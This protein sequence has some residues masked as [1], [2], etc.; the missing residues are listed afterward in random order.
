MRRKQ[1]GYY[2]P[3]STTGE[4]ADAFVPAPLPPIPPIEWSYNM[5]EKFD[6]ALLALGRLDG[7][8]TLLPDVPLFL[9][10][11]IR[12]EAVVSSMIE[13]T[14]SSLSDVLAFES[15]HYLQVPPDDAQEVSN[16]ARA[17]NYGLRRLHE[18]PLSV[19]LLREMHGILLASGRGEQSN[20]GAFRRSQNWIGGDRPSSASFVPPPELYVDD[21]M[22]ELEMFVHDTREKTPTLVKAALSHAQFE[23]IHPFQDG[24]GRMGRLMITLLLCAEGV[25]ERPMLYISVYFKT[26]RQQYYALLNKVR[27]TGDW[28]AW[29]DFFA[30]AVIHAA[31]QSVETAQRLSELADTDGQKIDTLKGISGTIRQ[32]HRAMLKR[33]ITSSQ[34]IQKETGLTATTVNACL[35]ELEKIGIIAEISGQQRNRLYRYT[36]YINIMDEGTELPA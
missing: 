11:Y 33:P 35:G 2:I 1:Q 13:G 3:I 20:P 22:R 10:T 32:I 34:W 16:Y 31:S 9:Y 5:R 26:H 6:Q 24:N 8:S 23:T 27:A 19:R 18:I 4:Q 15:K 14:Q 28:E 25:L 36:Q 7:V 30:D 17:L 21:L 12:K 29:L